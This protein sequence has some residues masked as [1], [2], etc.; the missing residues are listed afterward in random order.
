MK[1]FFLS[2]CGRF[3][4]KVIVS[5][6][7]VTTKQVKP[8]KSGEPYL[9]LTLSDRCGQIE[10]KMWDNVE[11]AI[12]AFE[13]DDFLKVKGLLNRYKN[14]FQLTIHKLRKLGDSEVDFADYL[15]KTTKDVDELW[16]TLAS[17][18]D[19]F[20][21]TNLKTLVHAFMAD[22]EIAAAYRN[23]PA[24]K[25]LHHAYIGGLLDHVVSLFR[26]CDLLCR[27]Y[28][29]INRDL[30]LTGA[31][32]HDIGKIHELAYSRSFS[33]TSRGQLLGHMIIEL[34]MLQGKIAH[35]P[36]FPD[37]L[38][39]LLEHLIISHHGEYEFGSPKLPMFPE[40]LMLHYL[41]DL[42]SKMESM[43]AHFE[44]EAEN[45]SSW[46][47]YNA[48]LGRTLLNTAKFLK[49]KEA[50]AAVAAASAADGAISTKSSSNGDGSA[51]SE[52]VLPFIDNTR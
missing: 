51:R 45:D 12:D 11:D 18:V 16:R 50:A 35:L 17:F 46:T 24:A 15:P 44:R 1:D 36:N 32:L 6:F 26:S 10:A 28:P 27:N 7:V 14:R 39:T 20:Q 13:Q 4:N 34:E 52:P 8:K 40:A 49:P 31:F 2:D 9:A 30:L 41:D 19:S 42:D 38:K 48:S 21:D 43:R 3:E 37:G 23:A 33:Y 5:T 22:P 29:Q 25:T 47:S